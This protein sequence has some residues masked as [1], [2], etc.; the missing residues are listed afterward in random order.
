MIILK[1]NDVA[2]ILLELFFLNK[3]AINRY[4]KSEKHITTDIFFTLIIFITDLSLQPV[5]S[6]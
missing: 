1:R 2:L 4:K 6:Q 3:I 5:L